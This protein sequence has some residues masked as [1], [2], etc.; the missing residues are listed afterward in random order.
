[1]I[2]APQQTEAG[3]LLRLIGRTGW[4]VL[5]RAERITCREKRESV[6][7]QPHIRHRD[8][9]DILR[10]IPPSEVFIDLS[11]ARVVTDNRP[12]GIRHLTQG[13][14]NRLIERL[15][16]R[17]RFRPLEWMLGRRRLKIRM[18]GVLIRN[19]T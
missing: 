18:W 4:R 11:G 9:S 16:N 12:H 15:A 10:H 6:L 7:R 1:M 19:M 3:R 17:R 8:G 5:W 14:G 13:A 2:W